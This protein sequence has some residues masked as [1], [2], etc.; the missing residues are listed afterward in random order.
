MPGTWSCPQELQAWPVLPSPARDGMV[1]LGAGGGGDPSGLKP[2]PATCTPHEHG[3]QGR[4]GVRL[5]DSSREREAH[6]GSSGTSPSFPWG[7]YAGSRFI[8][9]DS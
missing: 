4:L 2:I 9:L 6:G 8:P 1:V 5:W 3:G 7:F